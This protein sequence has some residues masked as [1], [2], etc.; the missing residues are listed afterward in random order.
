MFNFL[1]INIPLTNSFLDAI[2]IER[3]DFSPMERI[4]SSSVQFLFSGWEKHPE[5]YL[6]K[7]AG[8]KFRFLIGS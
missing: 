5:S 7:C 4:F 6:S 1:K 3:M 2:G 8:C